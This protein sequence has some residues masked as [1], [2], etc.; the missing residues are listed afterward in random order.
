M[1]KNA[2]G[3]SFRR[4]N[5]KP[6]FHVVVMRLLTVYN[7]WYILSNCRERGA[8]ALEE[9]LAVERLTAGESAKESG[10]DAVEDV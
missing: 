2:M 3:L 8:R 7:I 5:E 1:Q 10:R 9:R 6:I 4:K